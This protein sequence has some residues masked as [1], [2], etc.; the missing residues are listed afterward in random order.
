MVQYQSKLFHWVKWSSCQKILL[1]EASA[2]TSELAGSALLIGT[3]KI[4]S[5]VLYVIVHIT[6]GSKRNSDPRLRI[7]F[8]HG[9]NSNFDSK[10]EVLK[11]RRDFQNR[12]NSRVSLNP[13]FRFSSWIISRK[14]VFATSYW[15]QKKFTSISCHEILSNFYHTHK[16]CFLTEFTQFVFRWK[17]LDLLKIFLQSNIGIFRFLLEQVLQLLLLQEQLIDPP[18]LQVPPCCL[19]GPQIRRILLPLPRRYWA[20]WQREQCDK[21]YQSYLVQH[22]SVWTLSLFLYSSIFLWTKVL[23]RGKWDVHFL[24]T[25]VAYLPQYGPTPLRAVFGRIP[26]FLR[27]WSNERPL[28]NS[29]SFCKRFHEVCVPQ[30]LL[31]VVFSFTGDV[32]EHRHKK[33]SSCESFWCLS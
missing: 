1:V 9:L 33:N 30:T 32:V 10:L 26:L 13:S 16:S 2:I 14:C 19:A 29:K 25:H 24:Q 23:L 27:T 21:L 18:I 5:V 11:G 31:F 22:W 3:C 12:L 4:V 17:S 7:V 28:T 15:S 20:D 8:F 6:N